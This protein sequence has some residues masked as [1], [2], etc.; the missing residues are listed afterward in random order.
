[1]AN[2]YNASLYMTCRYVAGGFISY[3][4]ATT[5][6]IWFVPW[7]NLSILSNISHCLYLW[8]YIIVYRSFDLSSRIWTHIFTIPGISGVVPGTSAPYPG[9]NMLWID[10]STK[11]V[12]FSRTSAISSPE[13]AMCICIVDPFAQSWSY[14]NINVPSSPV[15]AWTDDAN[16]VLLG[17]VIYRWGGTSTLST[18]NTMWRIDLSDNTFVAV[19]ISGSSM[20]PSRLQY[21]GVAYIAATNAIYY[22]GGLLINTVPTSQLWIFDITASTWTLVPTIAPFAR[23]MGQGM[24]YLADDN[25][26]LILGGWELSHSTSDIYTYNIATQVWRNLEAVIEFPPITTTATII[27]RKNHACDWWN[28]HPVNGPVWLCTGGRSASFVIYSDTTILTV[29]NLVW[30]NAT[31]VPVMR[32][33]HTINIIG[34]TACVFGGEQDAGL[35]IIPNTVLI[36]DILTGKITPDMSVIRP[37]ARFGHVSATVPDGFV[38]VGGHLYDFSPSLPTWSDTWF[39]N[40]TNTTWI[41]WTSLSV[42]RPSARLGSTMALNADGTQLYLY[43][44]QNNLMFNFGYL[45]DT[46]VFTLETKQWTQLAFLSGSPNPGQRGNAA[47]TFIN[48]NFYVLGGDVCIGPNNV[49]NGPSPSADTWILNTTTLVW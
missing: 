33:Q 16:M 35:S 7:S 29:N 19:P 38:V 46:W 34:S 8:Y 36:F 9:M 39:Y 31:T 21:T 41:E 40:V 26:L 22:L 3:S 6:D 20:G 37:T 42:S 5:T 11:L 15:H 25:T 1:M 17:N 18:I 2:T 32:Y 13:L 12:V 4:K 24:H 43:G 45:D 30:H 14:P 10:D 27:P 49:G 47:S 44:G 28:T 48:G 23:A